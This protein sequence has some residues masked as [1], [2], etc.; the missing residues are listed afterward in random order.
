MKTNIQIIQ[1]VVDYI[2]SHLEDRLD[3]E[4]IS[5]QAG[6]SRYHLSRMFTSITGLSLHTYIQ[7]RRLTEAARQLV[8][9]DRPVMDIALSAGYGSQQAFTVGF[10]ALFRTSPRAFRKK[11]DFHPL[12]LKFTADGTDALRG[13]RIMDIRT[14]ESGPI[15]L[16]GYKKNT[17]LGFFVIG[18]CWRRLHA[19]KHTIPNRKDP[20]FLVGLNDYTKWDADA[21]RQPAFDYY[22]ASEQTQPGR[23]P[24][25][26]EAKEL[27]AGKYVI[28][29]F[30]ARSTDS[31]Q[32][33]ADYIYKTWFPQS[34]C[35][36]NGHAPYDFA[37]YGEE[38]DADGKSLIEYW[39]PII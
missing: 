4:S 20:D 30:R 23:L 14:M 35:R 26:M 1:E 29:R 10:R 16:A 31:L 36:L 12:Q 24:P 18:Q 28:F 38:M 11:G 15:Y 34:T 8:F 19:A 2:D 27:P 9:T 37:R 5:R 25:G 7:R 17:R 32:P 21:D 22:A 13:D 3:S 6:Y 33:V 39:L